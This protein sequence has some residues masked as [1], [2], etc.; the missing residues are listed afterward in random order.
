MQ[1]DAYSK[2]R[3]F[4][5]KNKYKKTKIN[6]EKIIIPPNLYVEF[7]WKACGFLNWLSINKSD[8]DFLKINKKCFLKK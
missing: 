5:K 3:I 2:K 1:N 8:L 7:S 6:K 4:L